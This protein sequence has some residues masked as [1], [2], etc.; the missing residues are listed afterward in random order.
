[1]EVFSPKLGRRLSLSS[2]ERWKC[3]LMIEA[4][5]MITSF[6]ERPTRVGGAASAIVDFWVELRG[7]IGGEF[8][9]FDGSESA[10]PVDDFSTVLQGLRVRVLSPALLASLEVPLSNWA[11][12][13]PY[14]V[15]YRNDRDPLLEQSLVVELRSWTS[16][17]ELLHR[18]HDQDGD[19]VRAGLFWLLA[20]GRVE[21]PDL[22]AAALSR[23]THFRR[24]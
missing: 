6:C 3:W 15:S 4:N 24:R 10:T 13:L 7:G 23:A 21:S 11:Q 5:P 20:S 8:W 2:Y 22:A 9:L 19:A 1:L 14:L 12:I 16:L 17:G 18:F